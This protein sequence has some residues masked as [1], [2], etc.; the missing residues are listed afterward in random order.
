MRGLVS[1]GAVGNTQA[2]GIS[3]KNNTYFVDNLGAPNWAY[4]SDALDRGRWQ[5]AGQD[6]TGKFLRW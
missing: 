1:F 3:F 6:E 2:P 4:F 5:A